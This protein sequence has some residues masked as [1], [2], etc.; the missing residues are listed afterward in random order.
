MKTLILVSALSVGVNLAFAEEMVTQVLPGQHAVVISHAKVGGWAVDDKVCIT[1]AGTKLGC[2]T[3]IQSGAKQATLKFSEPVKGLKVGDV[4]VVDEDLS[5]SVASEEDADTG[6]KIKKEKEIVATE[7][8]TPTRPPMYRHVMLG[9]NSSFSTT[10]YHINFQGY[11]SEHVTLGISPGI[12]KVVDGT[13]SVTTFGTVF[14]ANYYSEG[15][16]RGLWAQFAT[17]FYAFQAASGSITET[18]FSPALLGTVGWRNDW[19]LG[20]N[21]GI[22]LGAQYITNPQRSSVTFPFNALQPIL[23]TDIGFAF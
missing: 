13:F 19:A 11:I 10:T 15:P 20:L 17:G 8:K 21:V 12:F 5:R 6:E 16:F 18:T 3:V 1:R 14:T 2:G 22:G 7:I 23:V 9:A 4:A